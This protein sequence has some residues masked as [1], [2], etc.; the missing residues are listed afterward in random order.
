MYHDAI[1]VLN[2]APIHDCADSIVFKV[3]YQLALR[4]YLINRFSEANAHLNEMYYLVDSSY[5]IKGYL[6]HTI[7]LNELHEW[8]KSKKNCIN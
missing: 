2:S 1:N 3:K 4:N 6:L 5:H 7:I 8:E